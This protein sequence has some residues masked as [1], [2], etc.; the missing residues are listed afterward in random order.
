MKGS[1]ERAE[2]QALLLRKSTNAVMT[3]AVL[4][5]LVIS[6]LAIV[7]KACIMVLFCTCLLLGVGVIYLLILTVLAHLEVFRSSYE[8]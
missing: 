3:I 5:Y 2:K 1:V 4:V 7:N 6:V 8:Q